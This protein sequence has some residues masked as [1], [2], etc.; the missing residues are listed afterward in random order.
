MNDSKDFKKYLLDHKGAII[1]G[2][3]AIVIACT[4][5]VRILVAIAVIVLGIWSGNYIQKNKESV[6]E[7]LKNLIDK[8]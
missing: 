8:F 3:I 7:K 2:L 1:G 4:A 6:K 5:L